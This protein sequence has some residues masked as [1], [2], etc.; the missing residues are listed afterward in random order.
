MSEH[1][2]SERTP[3]HTAAE[4]GDVDAVEALLSSGADV[5]AAAEDGLT[6][7]HVAAAWGHDAV[8]EI[9][10]ARAADC[11]ARTCDGLTP[12][13]LAARH[14]RASTVILLR[15]HEINVRHRIR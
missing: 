7:L 14:E 10:L 8:A 15:Q 13:D 5:N 2:G 6:P 12:L 3:L 11:A 4:V 9:L 1:G